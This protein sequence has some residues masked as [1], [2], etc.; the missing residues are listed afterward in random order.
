MD[1]S[2]DPNL[3]VR[4]TSYLFSYELKIKIIKK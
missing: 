4:T 1:P 3:T 2:I